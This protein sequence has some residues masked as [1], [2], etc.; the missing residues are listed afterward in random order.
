MRSIF[1][2]TVTRLWEVIRRSPSFT[3]Y[4]VSIP[5][6]RVDQASGMPFLPQ[7]HYFQVRLNEMYLPYSRQW[8][9]TY[10]PMAA[11]L[12]EFQYG[13]AWQATPMVVGPG[14]I[15]EKGLPLPESGL[16]FQDTR[17]AGLHPYIGGRVTVAV[18]LCRVERQN[19]ARR[20]LGVLESISNGLEITPSWG[21]YLRIATTVLDGLQAL[22][23]GGQ[24]QPLLGFRKE[25]DPDSGS[26]FASG[27]F[28]L[29]ANPPSG[30]DENKLW[31]KG[32]RLCYGETS[33]S[34]LPVQGRSRAAAASA[35][36]LQSCEFVLYSLAQSARRSDLNLLPFYPLWERVQRE[37]AH[38]GEDHWLSAK[39]NML[40]LYQTL[41]TSPDLTQSQAR[42]LVDDYVARMREIHQMAKSLGELEARALIEGSPQEAEELERT[43]RRALSVLNF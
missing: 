39:A 23:D 3:P 25:F 5:P 9:S 27:Y 30:F 8:L 6:D 15:E 43:L 13:G 38:P 16:L 24:V 14:L 11:A 35:N 19:L 34:A 12:T 41:I 17:L 10:L 20:F 7:E 40:S 36:P 4:C 31:V 1:L 32:N 42:E 2:E 29:I 18:V 33:E 37:A 22:L 21:I 26:P 28:A